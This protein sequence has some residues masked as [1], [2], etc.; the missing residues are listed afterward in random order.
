[1]K[2]RVYHKYR[3]GVGAM[4][5]N[6]HNQV[7]VAK[8]VTIASGFQMPQGGLESNEDPEVCLYRELNEEIGT[9]K[10]SIIHHLP[11]FL[12]YNFPY[13]LHLQIYNGEYIGQRIQWFLLRFEG[14]DTDINLDNPNQEFSEWF[15]TDY[16]VL[17]ENVVGFKK[18]MYQT[19]VS[20]FSNY[21]SR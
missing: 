2:E 14:E 7:F 6:K 11:Y 5:V 16:K 4:I 3:D 10:F 21:F 12:H 9:T 17:V 13:E 1:M 20:E 8:R 18:T 15:W 19:V